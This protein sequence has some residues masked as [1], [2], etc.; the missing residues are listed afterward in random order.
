[1]PF[2]RLVGIGGFKRS[3]KDSL[4]DYLIQGHGFVKIAMADALRQE[5]LEKFR[6]TIMGHIAEAHVSSAWTVEKLIDE[7]P[8]PFMR[9][10]LQEFGTEVRREENPQYWTIKWIQAFLAQKKYGKSTVVPDV[11]FPNEASTVKAWGGVTICVNRPGFEVSD[12]HA[13]ESY[14]AEIPWDYTLTN[15]GTIDG[16]W[17]KMDQLWTS[18]ESRVESGSPSTSPL[19]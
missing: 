4:A 5:V 15:D 2:P 14:V 7:K 6:R 3:G 18:L 16:L 12:G 19:R 10:L 8:C 17:G 13:S 1:M 9:G 11:R